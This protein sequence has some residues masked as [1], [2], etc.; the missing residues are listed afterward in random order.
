MCAC[1]KCN[2]W[3]RTNPRLQRSASSERDSISGQYF[4]QYMVTSVQLRKATH[5]LPGARLSGH[6]WDLEPCVCLFLHFSLRITCR[7]PVSNLSVECIVISRGLINLRQALISQGDE[8]SESEAGAEERG[9]K[10]AT[11]HPARASF[12]DNG[13][14]GST[15]ELGGS[16]PEP[17]FS[18]EV[19]GSG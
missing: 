8:N 10:F 2:D 6:L 14:S 12:G 15:I 5:A 7:L 1:P 16:F 11:S 13:T 3:G 9:I 4:G 18:H 17:S 19:A